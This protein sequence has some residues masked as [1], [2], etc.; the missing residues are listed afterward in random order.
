MMRSALLLVVVVGLGCVCGWGPVTHQS[1][2]Y[3][4]GQYEFLIEY[5]FQ[6]GSYAPDALTTYSYTWHSLEYAGYQLLFAASVYNSTDIDFDPI[7]YSMGYGTHLANDYVGFHDGGWLL[8]SFSDVFLS[9]DTYEYLNTPQLEYRYYAPYV[10]QI[11]DFVSKSTEYYAQSHPGTVPLSASEVRMA[12]NLYDKYSKIFL[13]NVTANTDYQNILIAAD[14]YN[15]ANWAEC[16]EQLKMQLECCALVADFWMN[17][18]LLKVGPEELKNKTQEYTDSLY[19]SGVCAPL[20]QSAPA[21][22]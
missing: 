19:A 11:A 7:A 20:P 12:C 5:P 10:D 9:V 17:G 3:S 22:L 15:P 8:A 21:A 6:L 13:A 18:T 1:L 2:T 14:P 4:E 16:E